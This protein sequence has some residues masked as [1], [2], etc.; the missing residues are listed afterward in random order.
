MGLKNIFKNKSTL[1]QL[2]LIFSLMTVSVVLHIMF[3]TG[4]LY[5]YGIESDIIN[6]GDL[7]NPDNINSLKFIQ[8]FSGIGLFITPAFLYYYLTEFNFRIKSKIK[9][10]LVLLIIA[11][12]LLI[13]PFISFV[14]QWNQSFTFPSWMLDYDHQAELMT[15][16]FL[17]MDNSIDLII[18]LFV[19]AVVPAI[20]EELV[21]RGYLQQVFSVWLNNHMAIIITALLFSAI[22]LQFQGFIP[23]FILGLLLGYLFY[24]SNS[25]WIPIIAHFANNA[26]AII[27]SFPIFSNNQIMSYSGYSLFSNE[28]IID[29]KLAIFSF[30]SVSLLV[31][32]FYKRTKNL[33]FKSSINTIEED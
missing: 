14:F 11:I 30:L 22:H 9:R 8:L 32:I 6:N 17:Q 24:W 18:N 12:M 15:V 25:L 7:V 26:Q 23:R 27:F 20:G 19:L 10:D 1:F 16:A 21:F 2:G 28:V 31:Y 3:A 5:F 4:I 13:T 33:E 29:F